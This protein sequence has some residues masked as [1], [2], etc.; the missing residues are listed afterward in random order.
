MSLLLLFPEVSLPISLGICA[1]PCT[2]MSDWNKEAL[3]DYVCIEKSESP[4]MKWGCKYSEEQH[5]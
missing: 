5:G 2:N 1:K 4:L 3:K